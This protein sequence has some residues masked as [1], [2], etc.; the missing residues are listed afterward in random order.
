MDFLTLGEA[1]VVG[2]IVALG[3]II[4]IVWDLANRRKEKRKDDDS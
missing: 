2:G 4:A 1:L 3:L